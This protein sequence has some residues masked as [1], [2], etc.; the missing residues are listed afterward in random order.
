MK[1]IQ[2]ASKHS[3]TIPAAQQEFGGIQ[4]E[5]GGIWWELGG[6][7][8]TW[9]TL[10][11]RRTQQTGRTRPTQLGEFSEH[12]ELGERSELVNIKQQTTQRQ[13]IGCLCCPTQTLPT[14]A[15]L[16]DKI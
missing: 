4:K 8:R 13:M 14:R 1:L 10:R 12:G 5:L 3:S 11:T 7:R 9:Q 15:K 6:T 2:D 16:I